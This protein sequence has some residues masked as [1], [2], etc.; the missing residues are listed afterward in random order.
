[1]LSLR[2]FVLVSLVCIVVTAGVVVVVGMAADAFVF[3]TP[4]DVV[5]LVAGSVGVGAFA[6]VVIAVVVVVVGG[7][8]VVGAGV[9]RAVVGGRIVELVAFGHL[10][11]H[12][13]LEQVVELSCDLTG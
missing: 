6:L 13:E 8:V 2:A 11:T 4:G 1:M 5:V 3:V 7:T 9:G 10:S 12:L